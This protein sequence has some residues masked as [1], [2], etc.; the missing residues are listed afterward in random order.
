MYLYACVYSFHEDLFGYF[1]ESEKPGL[2]KQVLHCLLFLVEL[3]ASDFRLKL[4]QFL[5]F[6]QELYDLVLKFTWEV[7]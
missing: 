2:P 5:Q 7:G 4:N 1:F 6:N 3:V